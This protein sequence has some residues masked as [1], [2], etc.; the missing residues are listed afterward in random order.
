ML[1]LRPLVL[2]FPENGI[3]VPK[4]V[5]VQY[6][7]RFVIYYVHLS[8]DVLIVTIRMHNMSNINMQESWHKSLRNLSGSEKSVTFYENIFYYSLFKVN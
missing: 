4:H 3:A 1:R 2:E 5:A 6:F 7:S 8:A